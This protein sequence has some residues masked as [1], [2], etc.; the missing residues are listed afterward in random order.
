VAGKT[1]LASTYKTTSDLII[2]SLR[3]VQGSS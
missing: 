1:E 3:E 2:V